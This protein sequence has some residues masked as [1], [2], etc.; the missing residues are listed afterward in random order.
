MSG[1]RGRWRVAGWL[2]VAAAAL[3]VWS[4]QPRADSAGGLAAAPASA[5]P[6]SPAPQHRLTVPGR[7][8]RPASTFGGPGGARCGRVRTDPEI[9]VARGGCV[10]R[11]RRGSVA[12]IVNT[13]GGRLPFARCEMR[14][15]LHVDGSGRTVLAGVS[16]LGV[17]PC[18]DA[19]NCFSSERVHFPRGRIL[20]GPD[21]ELRHVVDACFDTCI[22]RFAGRM[23]STLVRDGRAW[24]ELAD[25]ALAAT[26]GW[27]L[28]GDWR[29]VGRMRI[30]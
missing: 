19:T 29:L 4:V 25:H 10:M 16:F 8:A 18:N 13:L 21:G 30:D 22:G 7:A 28:D 12:L 9:G 1:A 27:E 26:S 3:A 15:T 5:S 14:Y 23:E 11:A 6:A 20:R 17:S 24:R 2:L